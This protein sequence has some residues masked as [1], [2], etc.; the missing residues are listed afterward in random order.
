MRKWKVLRTI[1]L[2]NQMIQ[3]EDAHIHIEDCGFQFGDGIYEVIKVYNGSLFTIKEHIDRFY[4]CAEKLQIVIP[5]TKDLLH[6]MLYDLVE[7]NELEVGHVYMQITRGVA[8]RTH[9][10]PSDVA[11]TFVAYTQQ[12]DRPL[13]NLQRG[14]RTIFDEDIRWLR[15]DIKSLN[16]LGAVLSKQKAHEQGCY[17]A[18][19]HRDG[20]ITEGSSSNI[21]GIKD[22]VLYTHPVNNYILNGITRHVLLQCCEEIGLPVV[23][24]AMT[25]ERA[26]EMDELLLTSTTSEVTP[27]IEVDCHPIADG[28]PGEW[29]R[30]LQQAFELKVK[31]AVMI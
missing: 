26:L 7:E 17:E 14:V 27:I 18:I 25:C 6:K 29:T 4:T 8:S 19:L 30:R 15:C 23:E 12:G 24:E 11:P 28:L 1:L 2:N 21:F 31:T 22:G 9:F 10:F 20:V 13:Q 16:L 3:A 5:Y